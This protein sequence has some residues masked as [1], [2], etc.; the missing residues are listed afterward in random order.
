MIRSKLEAAIVAAAISALCLACGS[1]DPRPAA[2]GAAAASA[3]AAA[4][5]PADGASNHAPVVEQVTISPSAPDATDT[6]QAAVRVS[7]ADG[8]RA[9]VVYTWW[10]NGRKVADGPRF[11]LASASRGAKV[12]VSVVASDGRAQSEPMNASVTLANSPPRIERIRFE[13][14]GAWHA[15]QDMAAL[16]EAV[17]PDGDPLTFDYTWIHNGRE[18]AE[19][20]PIFNGSILTRGDRVQLVVVASDGQS[21]SEAVR[22]EE[23]TVSNSDPEIVSTPGAIGADGVF[24]YQVQASDPD[25]D[26]AFMY[27]LLQAPPGMD[28]D[29]L[30]GKVEWKPAGA[31]AGVNDIEVEVDDRMGGR[32]TQRFT[33]DV[34]FTEARIPPASP[35]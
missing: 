26:R 12:E 31:H 16:P 1:E 17:D 2:S 24:R 18:I 14:S 8:D 11:D 33:L 35:D 22:S 29:V 34:T 28:I 6:L 3:R 21:E 13:P 25:G 4:A 30:G 19:D 5:A 7:D 27:R 10:M 32:A 20:G 23:I 9:H 15:R